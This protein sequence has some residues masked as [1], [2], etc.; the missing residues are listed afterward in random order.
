MITLAAF[1]KQEFNI[2]EVDNKQ[3]EA[4][5]PAE[6]FRIEKIKKNLSRQIESNSKLKVASANILQDNDN[7]VDID[8]EIEMRW[9]SSFKRIKNELLNIDETLNTDKVVLKASKKVSKIKRAV[10]S[11][12]VEIELM[13]YSWFV[14]LSAACVLVLLLAVSTT[15]FAP[16]FSNTITKTFDSAFNLG[17]EKTVVV[18][19]NDSLIRRA[20]I[21]KKAMSSYIVNNGEKLKDLKEGDVVATGLGG[22]R[23]GQVAG[24]METNDDVDSLFMMFLKKLIKLD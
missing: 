13:E 15:T 6:V 12:E 1:L 2:L 7:T 20:T 24:V 19:N 14:K 3:T 4:V 10:K 17:Q 9:K 23:K 5:E 18:D 8:D 11:N 22:Q 16:N 21:S